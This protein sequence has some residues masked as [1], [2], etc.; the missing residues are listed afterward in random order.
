MTDG[1][2][3]YLVLSSGEQI[4]LQAALPDVTP[5]AAAQQW[6]TWLNTQTGY[7]SFPAT[8]GLIVVNPSKISHLRI[9]KE[10]FG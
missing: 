7:H 10:S 3:V 1:S 6:T 5:E 2:S 8:D 9:W 4:Q